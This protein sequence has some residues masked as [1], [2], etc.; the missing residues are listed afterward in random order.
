MHYSALCVCNLDWFW[1]YALYESV[2]NNTLRIASSII[3][4]ASLLAAPDV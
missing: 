3:I 2:Q 4:A 1:V